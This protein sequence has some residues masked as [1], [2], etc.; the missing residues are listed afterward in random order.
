[1]S[2]IGRLLQVI[3]THNWLRAH[4][5]SSLLMP[6]AT[7]GRIGVDEASFLGQITRELSGPGPIIEIGTLF[8]F[9]A[10]VIY[11]NMTPD[12]E[13]VT[14]DNFS[15]NPY[16]LSPHQHETRAHTVLRDMLKSG[17]VTLVTQDKNEFYAHYEGPNPAMVFLDADHSYKE[18]KADLD[19][20]RLVKAAVICGHDYSSNMPGVIRA[21]DE[22]GGYRKLVGSLWLLK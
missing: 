10:C 19:W 15:W 1:M 12:R 18:T 5:V 6:F 22:A 7:A 4:H 2:V 3:W 14:V 8:G 16:G 9:S 20:A 17:R 11:Q 21:V 13:L